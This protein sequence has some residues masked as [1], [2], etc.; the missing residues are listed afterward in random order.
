MIAHHDFNQN[1]S[2]WVKRFA[3]LAPKNSLVLDLACGG[4]RHA[5]LFADLGYPVL[6]VDQ[7]V[8]QVSQTK[9]GRI[10]SQAMDLESDEWPLQGKVFGAIVVTNYLF[11][12]HLDRL[13]E[14]LEEGGILIYETFAQGNAQFGRPSN[15]NFLLKPGELLT[16]AA[17][18]GLKVVAYE[19]LYVDDPKP[20]MVQRLCA[21]KG[22][23]KEHIPLQFQG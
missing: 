15:P 4:G 8:S 7:D 17:H 23:L 2:P 18:H 13:P 9:E 19:D 3:S 6:A 16:L 11:R 1:A 10:I 20:A 21:V 14:M 22:V 12:P 5:R